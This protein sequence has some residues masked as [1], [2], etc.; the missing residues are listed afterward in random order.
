MAV[1]DF[2]RDV[3]AAAREAGL[4]LREGTIVEWL[5]GWGH[6]EPVAAD[7][8][9][10][11]LERLGLMHAALGGDSEMLIQKQRRKPKV[12][13]WLG[14]TVIVELD[15]L[16]HFSS[17]RLSTLPFYEGLGHA[18]DLELYR[19][20]CHRY[21]GPA[22]KKYSHKKAKDF[23]FSG[24]RTAQRAYLDAVRDLLAPVFGLRVIRI[25]A[26]EYNVTAAVSDLMDFLAAKTSNG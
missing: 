6:R 4:P 3:L 2:A 1:G 25:P 18:L 7:T 19:S 20:L 22:H 16:Q 21:H 24:G 5:S 23:A 17:Y 12:D 9:S 15:E 10:L 14:D 8:P 26:P 11:V 13:F